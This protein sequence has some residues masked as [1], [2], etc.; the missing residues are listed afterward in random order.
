MNVTVAHQLDEF[1]E[2]LLLKEGM[3]AHDVEKIKRA[4]TYAWRRIEDGSVNTIEL[5]KSVFAA[6][7]D[8]FCT[9]SHGG[10]QN[11]PHNKP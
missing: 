7:A 3:S 5:A 11:C 10:G 1:V 6:F 9:G 2:A 4:G 8:G